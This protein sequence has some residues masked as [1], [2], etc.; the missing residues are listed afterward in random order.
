MWLV[1]SRCDPVE[2]VQ[3]VQAD[4]VSI[5]H[6]DMHHPLGSARIVFSFCNSLCPSGVVV[7]I[8]SFAE[9]FG[10]GWTAAFGF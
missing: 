1:G 9:Q 4:F 3:M 5:V 8:E 6:V 2:M 10:G 7:F